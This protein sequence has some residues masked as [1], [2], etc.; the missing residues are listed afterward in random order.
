MAQNIPSI[1]NK[2]QKE[3]R[4]CSTAVDSHI[5]LCALNIH[6][7]IRLYTTKESKIHSIVYITA[8]LT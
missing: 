1:Y 6:I 5:A 3:A 2:Q 7:N 8:L 4:L